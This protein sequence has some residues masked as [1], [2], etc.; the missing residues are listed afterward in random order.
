[1]C[2]TVT[3]QSVNLFDGCQ[4]T[5]RS[6]SL[7]FPDTPHVNQAGDTVGMTYS[8]NSGTQI[9][10]VERGD[11]HVG[12]TNNA[13]KHAICFSNRGSEQVFLLIP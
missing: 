13:P 12:S 8:L 6:K 9:V 1:M 3:D 10:C 7:Q 5:V 4:A 2:E 11:F